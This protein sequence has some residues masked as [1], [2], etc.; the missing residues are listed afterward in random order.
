MPPREAI[1][2]LTDIEEIFKISISNE[3]I[4]SG[5]FTTFQNLLDYL[6]GVK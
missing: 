3:F 2:L 1:L 5:G 4:L 6:N